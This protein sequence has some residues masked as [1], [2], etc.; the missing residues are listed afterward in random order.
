MRY[1]D[2]K[3]SPDAGC[4]AFYRKMCRLVPGVSSGPCRLYCVS[5]CNFEPRML[6]DC[7]TQ[8]AESLIAAVSRERHQ[9]LAERVREISGQMNSRGIF[10][11]SIHVNEVANVCAAELK[12]I[13]SAAWDCVR[14]AHESCGARENAKVLPY[15][16]RV[17]EAE[18]A[19]A[20]AV[21]Q[22]AVGLIAAGLQNKSMVP[23]REVREAQEHLAAK[24]T[25]EIE[26][27]VANLS[28]E[29][30]STVL[31]RWTEVAP[32]Y[33]TVWPS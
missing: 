18:G 16:L 23:M 3:P 24:Y 6:K 4:V 33:R 28:R 1:L 26:I 8:R 10:P 31:E 20:E 15:F 12:E 27:Y 11:S 21:L 14:R 17:I 22:Q 2:Y 32:I 9:L 13:A 25:A 5:L 19:K 7:L 30:G 29:A